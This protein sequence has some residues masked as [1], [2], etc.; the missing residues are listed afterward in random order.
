MLRS[1]DGGLTWSKPYRVPVNSPHG[2]SSLSNGRLLYVGKHLWETGKG[3]GA[4][5]STDDGRTWRQISEIPARPGD[6]AAE[7]HE[8][9]QIEAA[10]GRIVVHIRNHN[11]QNARETLQCESVDG[12]KTWSVPHPIGVWGLPSHLLRLRDGTL[13]M[14]YGYR[15]APF[16]NQARISRDHGRTWSG[17]ITLSED[18][19]SGD[20]GYPSTVELADGRLLTVWYEQMKDSPRAVLRMARWK[21]EG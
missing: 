3:V 12:G 2:P 6:D 18:G 19:A 21:L 20:L 1:T 5:E 4:C 8:L 11:P 16:G 9:H 17:P 13:V 14:S 10:N 7:Y 15:R